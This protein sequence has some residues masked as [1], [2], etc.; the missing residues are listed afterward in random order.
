MHTRKCHTND[1]EDDT[2]ADANG[3]RTRSN[4]PHPLRW[5]DIIR[6]NQRTN[7]PVSFTWALRICWIR[8]SLEMHDYMLYKLSPMQK[9]YEYP[10]LFTKF[11]G[12][13]PLGSE[14]GDFLKVFTTY[15]PGSN[16]GHVTRN[17]FWWRRYDVSLVCSVLTSEKRRKDV[18]NMCHRLKYPQGYSRTRLKVRRI[19][20]T[21]LFCNLFWC[22]NR[23]TRS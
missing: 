12:H 2:N 18:Q 16:L 6:L 13:R 7:G 8:I 14:E 4:M 9:H 1:T 5:S 23:N 22:S 21:N 3:I 17:D 10:M 15:G 20:R 19:W 11:Q